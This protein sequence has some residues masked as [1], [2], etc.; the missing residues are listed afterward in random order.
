MNSSSQTQL[1]AATALVQLLQEHPELHA[2]EWSLNSVIP[3]LRGFL[4][5]GDL[6]TLAAYA[7]VVGGN[8][9]AEK[10]YEYQ[11]KTLRRHILT[12]TWRDVPI[13]LVVTLPVVSEAVAA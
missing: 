4:Y 11:G 13:E 6:T 7:E 3:A 8:V 10:T 9:E 1:S 5:R 12:T 2:A